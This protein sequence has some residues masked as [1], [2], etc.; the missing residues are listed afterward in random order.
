MY[1][2]P[3][4]LPPATDMHQLNDSINLVAGVHDVYFLDTCIRIQD[5]LYVTRRLRVSFW[6]YL[7]DILSIYLQ[8]LQNLQSIRGYTISYTLASSFLHLHVASLPQDLSTWNT[9]AP[10]FMDLVSLLNCD[11]HCDTL[12]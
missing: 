2:L 1:N 10:N 11:F 5:S 7:T 3:L 8:R 9:I 12:I 4:S 6:W